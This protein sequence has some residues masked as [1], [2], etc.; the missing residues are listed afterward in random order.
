MI[1][2]IIVPPAG[3]TIWNA[4]DKGAELV[5][6]NN[7]LTVAKTGVVTGNHT[8]VRGTTSR[9]TGSWQIEA[10]MQ[11][12][13]GTGCYAQIGFASAAHPLNSFLG[14]ATAHSVGYADVGAIVV[15]NQFP[16]VVTYASGDVISCMIEAD[17]GRTWFAKNGVV[18]RGIPGS[19]DQQNSFPATPTNV[20]PW[21]IAFA[22]RNNGDGAILRTK[23]VDF[24]YPILSGFSA[25][26][27]A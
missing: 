22:G 18:V 13:K 3:A 6:S 11:A 20:A 17:T 12:P 15:N 1:A 4:A 24:Q 23:A 8:T 7:D 27:A 10:V 19:N 9:A 5:L 16:A 21:F 14:D 25:W 2:G 26:D